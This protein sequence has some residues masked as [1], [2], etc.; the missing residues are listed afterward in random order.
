[1]SGPYDEPSRGAPPQL[2]ENESSAKEASRFWHW[3]LYGR[4]DEEKI[5]VKFSLIEFE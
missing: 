5:V 3:D 1:M 4:Y 2:F